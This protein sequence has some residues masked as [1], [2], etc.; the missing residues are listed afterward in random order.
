MS[1]SF[2]CECGTQ[3]RV[4]DEMADKGIC[5]PACQAIQVVATAVPAQD[6]E[7]AI[8]P[9]TKQ[10]VA[11]A[12][13]RE[14]EPARSGP[15][16]GKRPAKE[17]SKLVLWLV[18]GGVVAVLG[19]ASAAGVVIFAMGWL[20]GRPAAA[21]KNSPFGVDQLKLGEGTSKE[22]NDEVANLK[23]LVVSEPLLRLPTKNGHYL[24]I[25]PDGKWIAFAAIGGSEGAILI[26]AASG[27]RHGHCP[28]DDAAGFSARML[29]FTPDSKSL[30]VSRG[31]D[32]MKK[33]AVPDGKPEEVYH[34]G[35][36]FQALL[37]FNKE[38]RLEGLYD[39]NEKRE[40]VFKDLHA[41]KILT[42]FKLPPGSEPYVS[43]AVSPD[44]TKG[45]AI[46]GE[47]VVLVQWQ[48]KTSV[49]TLETYPH[50]L[51]SG[52]PVS[53]AGSPTQGFVAVSTAQS[54]KTPAKITLWDHDSG[55]KKD[56]WNLHS[57]ENVDHLAMSLDGTWLAAATRGAGFPGDMTISIWHL[58]TKRRAV[59]LK[60][61]AKSSGP[62]AF[63]ADLS[64]L[65]LLA[66]DGVLY[67]WDL[68]K[69]G[70][71]NTK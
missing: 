32:R 69:A 16:G 35:E 11:H 49:K 62:L 44:G 10:P 12:V 54:P 19:F 56:S 50:D 58:P 17:S 33:L 14:E 27:K 60:G 59:V 65:A 64:R 1:I 5:C 7:P 61:M 55:A 31:F 25:S 26:D 24:A 13:E 67:V 52:H 39:T 68:T 3:L 45:I 15:G 66:D 51:L 41:D 40:W 34:E 63:S 18:L 21:G 4:K 30:L 29:L 48:P 36:C 23:P 38:G 6:G 8:A 47:N 70:L 57:G 53:T 42:R 20:N 71:D 9:A 28:N 37:R 2:Q 46:R 22:K 43:W